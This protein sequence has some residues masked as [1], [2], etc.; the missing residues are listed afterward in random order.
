MR[1]QVVN[2]PVAPDTIY[3]VRSS[4]AGGGVSV[5]DLNGF[6]CSTGNPTFDPTY[7]S[8]QEGWSNYVNN[9]NFRFQGALLGLPAPSSTLDGGSAGV[10]T[11]TKN[12]ALED[13]LL[14]APDIA[15]VGDLM[16]GAPLDLAFNDGPAPFGCQAGG[17]NLCAI[18]GQQVLSVTSGGPNTLA[19]GPL[20]SGALGLIVHGGNPISFAPH[21]NPPPIKHTPSCSV[22][23]IAAAEPTPASTSLSNLLVPGDPFG[24]PT[25]GVPPSGLLTREQNTFFMGPSA[26]TGPIGAC[27]T[28]VYRQQVGHFLYM[29]DRRARQVVVVNSNT[30]DVVTR[31]ATPDPTELAMSPNVDVLA[32]SNRDA[33]SVSFIDIDPQSP[34]FHTVF[35]VTSVEDRPSGIAWDPGNEDILVCNEGSDSVSILS[36][37]TLQV[38]KRVTR[39]LHAPFGVAITQRQATFGFHRNVYFAYVLDRAGKVTLFESGPNGPN[40]WG[41][42]QF[43]GQTSATFRAPKAIQP[44]PLDLRSAVWIA[45]EG[46]LDANGA[47]TSLSGGALT[48]L[49]LDSGV[50]GAIPLLPNEPPSMRSLTFGIARSIGTDEL[51]GNPLDIAFDDQRNLG[52]LPNV[53]SV[54]AAGP[55]APINGKSQVRSVRGDVRN[56]NEATY[57][58]VAVRDPST[59][60]SSGVDVIDLLTGLRV[61]T[62]AFRPGI[63]SIPARGAVFVAD[64]FR[65]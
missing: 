18:D 50:M 64:Y 56:T 23:L 9:P 30:F 57:L 28:Y 59:G 62:N 37:A 25:N 40:G 47:P 26:D 44:D 36:A 51:T 27:P 61:D 11:L 43:I 13:L 20:F 21:P 4:P 15:S 55:P 19:P 33:D 54:F 49:V 38:R 24:D 5:I 35:H 10:F 34:T 12:S 48:K 22:P 63:Q 45:H 58:F 60:V 65:Q 52:A 6:G 1:A 8:F 16:I 29:I 41:F 39:G 46:Q 42:D 53:S 2:A 32:V 14:R 31:I 7:Q 3:V 17:G